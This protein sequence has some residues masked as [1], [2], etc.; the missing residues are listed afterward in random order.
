MPRP[1][2][3]MQQARAAVIGGHRRQLSASM[4][5]SGQESDLLKNRLVV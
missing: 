3:E 4:T 2:S 5:Q 1:V